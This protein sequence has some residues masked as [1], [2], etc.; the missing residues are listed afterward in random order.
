MSEVVLRVIFPAVSCVCIRTTAG[1]N[2]LSVLRV[3]N[4]DRNFSLRCSCDK[5]K[6]FVLAY[7]E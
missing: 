3:M 4:E 2:P 1:L 6:N 5:Q 7:E